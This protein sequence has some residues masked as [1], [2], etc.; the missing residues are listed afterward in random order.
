VFDI[1]TA[2]LKGSLGKGRRIKGHINPVFER[3][4]S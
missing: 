2:K 1:G 4:S 3:K